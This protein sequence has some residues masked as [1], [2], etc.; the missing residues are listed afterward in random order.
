MKR[1]LIALLAMSTLLGGCASAPPMPVINGFELKHYLGTWHEVA[2]MENRFERGLTKV[3]AEYRDDAG[4][5]KVINRGFSAEDNRW[6]EAIG[7]ARFASNP[8]EGRLEVS[9]FGPFYGDYQILAATRDADGR[10]RTALVAGDSLEYLWL[11]SREP[12]LS[13]D[14]EAKFTSM[15]KSLGVEPQSLVWLSKPQS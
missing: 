11:L 7:K 12:N 15:I 9:F 13:A 14:E 6:K 8:D 1:V 3:T 4:S 10:Y 2:R 5:I